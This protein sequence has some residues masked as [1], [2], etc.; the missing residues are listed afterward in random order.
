MNKVQG[1]SCGIIYLN[2]LFD[3][4][5]RCNFLAD[6]RRLPNHNQK[7]KMDNLEEEIYYQSE[8]FGNDPVYPPNYQF[9]GLQWS[10]VE[11]K[12]ITDTTEVSS[13]YPKR[14]S[15]YEELEVG[16]GQSSLI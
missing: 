14:P 7:Y 1:F 9:G 15:F 10:A 11:E 6:C 13:A 2:E 8:L 16:F 12:V 3:P 5:I 4:Y